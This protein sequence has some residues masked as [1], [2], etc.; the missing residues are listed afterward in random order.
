MSDPG[1]TALTYRFER[2]RAISSG[3]I[4][5]AGTTFL[6]LI[7]VRY[8]EAGSFAKALVAAGGSAGLL[9]APWIVTRVQTLHWPVSI[10]AS[11]LAAL[12]AITFL[13][14]ALVPIL[15]V[16]VVG[17]VVAMTTSSTAIPLL[18]QIYQEN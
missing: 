18:T 5:T 16:F 15:P 12:G 6:L 9:I 14:M 8:Y 7:A 10:A 11:R 4:E 13:V 17:S 2:W 3:V 1:R